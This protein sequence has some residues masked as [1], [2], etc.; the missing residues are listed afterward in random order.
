[1]PKSKKTRSRMM[2]ALTV[3]AWA[4]FIATA[5]VLLSGWSR[6][7]DEYQYPPELSPPTI[8]VPPFT[9]KDNH[10]LHCNHTPRISSPGRIYGLLLADRGRKMQSHRTT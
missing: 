9:E 3:I 5:A 6:A 7:L 1:M 10:G 4:F 8:P 2:F